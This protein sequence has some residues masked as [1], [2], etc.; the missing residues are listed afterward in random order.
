MSELAENGGTL[1]EDKIISLMKQLCEI[2]KQL[3]NTTPAIIHRDIKPSNIIISTDGL[4]KLLDMNAA[5]WFHAQAGQD[6]TLIGTVGYAAPEQYG[7]VASSVQTDIYSV[8]VL[9]NVLLT[10]TF[11]RNRMAGGLLGDIIA[12]CI[13]M[14]PQERYQD[15]SQ[16]LEALQATQRK[17]SLQPIKLQHYTLPGFR[18]HQPLKMVA[19][20]IGY[21]FI[22]V[23]SLTATVETG[24]VYELW[25]SRVAF[26]ATMLAIVF[27]S[28]NYLD[29]WDKFGLSKVKSKFLR[30]LLIVLLDIAIFIAGATLPV[31]IEKILF[32]S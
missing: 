8:G 6:T 32:Q 22:F 9:M 30:L 5:K 23:L 16:V 27:F 31:L 7:F 17:H 15:I 26:A 1:P 24:E 25:L 29:V 18:S 13:K 10:G 2:L 21:V 12:K 19:A 4:V 20:V 3:H 28:C 11:P 14:E